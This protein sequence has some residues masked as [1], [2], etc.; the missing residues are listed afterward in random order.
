MLPGLYEGSYEGHSHLWEV[1]YTTTYCNDDKVVPLTEEEC[2][3]L[4]S[5]K[6]C[7][8]CYTVYSTSG[9]LAWGVG[10]KVGDIV[11]ARLPGL[12]REVY[13]VSIIRSVGV[14][15]ENGK[16]MLFGVEIKVSWCIDTVLYNIFMFITGASVLRARE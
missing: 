13:A 12:R 9:R 10:L 15:A 11:L 8:D 4:D 3:L 1:S 16:R 7:A 2:V 14:E 5:I 6:D